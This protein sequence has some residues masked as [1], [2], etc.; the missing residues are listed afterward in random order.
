[1]NHNLTCIHDVNIYD[2]IFEIHV[3]QFTA[4]ETGHL[5]IQD[6]Q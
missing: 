2:I 6:T 5:L 1:M 4:N 3:N